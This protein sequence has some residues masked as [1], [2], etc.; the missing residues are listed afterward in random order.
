[1]PGLTAMKQRQTLAAAQ[2]SWQDRIPK[3]L[4]RLL[5]AGTSGYPA[6]E[7][8]GLIATNVTG[9]L[10]T[11]SSLSYALT[12]AIQDITGL[13]SLVYGNLL[14]AT[15]TASVPLVHRLGRVAGGLLLTFTIFSTIFYFTTV[16][17]REAGIQLNYLGAAAIAFL[18]LGV[19]RIW[20]VASV[21]LSAAV[22]H[23]LAWFWYP[24]GSSALQMPSQFLSPDLCLFGNL[25]HDDH[26]IGDLLRVQLAEA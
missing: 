9:Y 10:A 18:I 17:G 23:L 11:L 24:P 7:L 20:L 2:S 19:E 6:A 14:S 12:Y 13:K 8:P 5:K 16:V 3:G 22:L 15:L 21:I 26:L 1:M 25:H 4:S